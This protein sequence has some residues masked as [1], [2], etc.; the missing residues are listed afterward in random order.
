MFLCS[1]CWG[2]YK[3]KVYKC[4]KC[5]KSKLLAAH[6]EFR[7]E[8]AHPL[9]QLAEVHISRGGRGKRDWITYGQVGLV[10]QGSRKR[11]C[12]RQAQA[13][14]GVLG[15]NERSCPYLTPTF[16]HTSQSKKLCS[17]YPLFHDPS[18]LLLDRWVKDG[19]SWGVT[20]IS[21]VA[22]FYPSL[23]WQNCLVVFPPAFSV[24][25]GESCVLY[26]CQSDRWNGG[27]NKQGNV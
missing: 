27:G 12:R 5:K 2:P 16:L 21:P 13:E 9:H 24:A 15:G 11:G 14:W 22:S 3:W 25:E 26:W 23:S 4:K 6:L 18:L 19:H 20:Y 1:G 7:P 10:L 17:V 8:D